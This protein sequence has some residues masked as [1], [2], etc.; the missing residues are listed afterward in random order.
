MKLLRHLLSHLVLIVFLSG[1]VALYYYRY[2]ILPDS[3]TEIMDNYTIKIH[4][5][6]ARFSSHGGNNDSEQPAKAVVVNNKTVLDVRTMPDNSKQSD[7]IP[8]ENITS[9]K[10]DK[11]NI[12]TEE[13][14][15]DSDIAVTS[16]NNVEED[17]A[18]SKIVTSSPGID[19]N[20]EQATANVLNADVTP[21]TSE[22][23][24]DIDKVITDRDSDS[25][26]DLL[27]AARVA[28]NQGDMTLAIEKY[29]ALIELDNDE[30]DFH[31][32]LGNVFYASGDWHN[33]GMEYYKAATRLIEA[34]DFSQLGYLQRVIQG[35]DP[36]RADKLAARLKQ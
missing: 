3:Y 33:A 16:D 11:E 30:A 12:A 5:S 36:E 4:P 14:M 17:N 34:G 32:E 7:E 29:Q 25:T 10:V 22:Q 26:V 31:G 1:V 24:D 18:D 9:S 15:Q 28:F 21:E 2:Q 13:A 20:S 23:A 35:L 19:D 27:R 8:V 6:I